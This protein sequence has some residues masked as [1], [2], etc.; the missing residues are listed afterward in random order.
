MTQLNYKKFNFL[1]AILI[2][3]AT[4]ISFS[5]FLNALPTYSA[6]VVVDLKI[7]GSDGNVNNPPLFYSD[8]G[9][10]VSWNN[11]NV[12]S[13]SWFYKPSNSSESAH[14]AVD[15]PANGQETYMIGAN[16]V[17]TTFTMICQKGSVSAQDQVTILYLNS[18]TSSL[19][20]NNNSGPVVSVPINTDYTVTWSASSSAGWNMYSIVAT[21]V[22]NWLWQN[23]ASYPPYPNTSFT[24]KKNTPGDYTYNLAVNDL[25]TGGKSVTKSIIARV[26]AYP[27]PTVDLKI[28]SSDNP[29]NISVGDNIHLSWTS[30]NATSCTSSGAWTDSIATSG[31][32]DKTIAS[33]GTRTY[34]VTCSGL[35]GTAIDS[36]SFTPIVSPAT[37]DMK[38]NGSDG[39]VKD[40]NT[41][42]IGVF[43][44][45]EYALSWTSSRA[46]SCSLKNND[47]NISS[48][49]NGT[50]N[51]NQ[52]GELTTKYSLICTGFDNLNVTQDFYVVITS[53]PTVD[54]KVNGKDDMVVVNYGESLYTSWKSGNL[55]LDSKCML[56]KNDSL[57]FQA[58]VQQE[59]PI[60]ILTAHGDIQKVSMYC[61]KR[62][63]VSGLG[64]ANYDFVSEKD[65]VRI[66]SY[67]LNIV[68]RSVG[69]TNKSPQRITLAN[70]NSLF[71]VTINDADPRASAGD[72]CE[73]ICTPFCLNNE[74]RAHFP[75]SI[76]LP[77]YNSLMFSNVDTIRVSKPGT[78][79]ILV[80]CIH[81]QDPVDQ[82]T[83]SFGT[84]YV[85]APGNVVGS[86]ASGS[87]IANSFNINF[88]ASNLT[89]TINHYLLNNPPPLFKDLL[90]PIYQEQNP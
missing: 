57:L 70:F 45:E 28:N 39:I 3:T 52:T 38:I 29:A 30:G 21:G 64:T 14:L 42:Y 4:I 40:I 41:K 53:K 7:N 13:C 59:N 79:E 32:M 63:N 25:V 67:Y 65:F 77:Y 85:E 9:I 2:I 33:T 86:S 8:G 76:V 83:V 34:V 54:L 11:Q 31:V 46:L 88:S 81:S 44:G 84:V 58:G 35:G 43:S 26:P 16:G 37:V 15:P 82:V 22:W 36:V 27:A 6:D 17:A 49:K 74:A 68:L 69:G 72:S 20:I 18:P 75:L 80:K 62:V 10:T 90:A 73:L 19:K 71:N 23:S 1:R 51:F 89:F 48:G 24:D 55:N 5:Y 78:T 87:F 12:D 56:E 61:V 66:G 47:T 60:N 50:L